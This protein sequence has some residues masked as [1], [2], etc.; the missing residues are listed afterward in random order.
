MVD[1]SFSTVSFKESIVAG[2]EIP[3]LWQNK[4]FI[5]KNKLRLL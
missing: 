5:I 3:P 1:N 2:A 4:V